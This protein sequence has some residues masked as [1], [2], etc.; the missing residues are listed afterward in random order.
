MNRY[1]SVPAAVGIEPSG[2]AVI[3]GGSHV[4]GV[5][6]HEAVVGLQAM[7]EDG[8]A[9]IGI[10][11]AGDT[12]GALPLLSVNRVAQ[13]PAAD[14]LVQRKRFVSRTSNKSHPARSRC[15]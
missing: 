3:P 14:T 5:T 6:V 2:I 10:A 11:V 12:I 15:S 8:A 7:A 13:Y 9:P 1:G 4:L